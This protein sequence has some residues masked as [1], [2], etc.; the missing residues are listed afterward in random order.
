MNDCL[1]IEYC[2]GRK[3]SSSFSGLVVFLN[4]LRVPELPDSS[5]QLPGTL[6]KH[7]QFITHSVIP[8]NEQTA[9]EPRGG[10]DGPPR[11]DDAVLDPCGRPAARLALGVEEGRGAEGPEDH[12]G[13]GGPEDEAVVDSV[14]PCHEADG[15]KEVFNDTFGLVCTSSREGESLV[16]DFCSGHASCCWLIPS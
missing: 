15:E 3:L 2:V 10:G 13:D 1:N 16:N 7:M 12:G 11:E 14:G 9:G 8:L 5:Y 4:N 6:I